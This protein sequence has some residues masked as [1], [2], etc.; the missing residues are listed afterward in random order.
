MTIKAVTS[1]TPNI[2]ILPSLANATT[3]ALGGN[4][5]AGLFKAFD[6]RKTDIRE[7]VQA[8]FFAKYLKELDGKT[9]SLSGFMQPLGEDLEVSSFMLIEYPVGCWYCEVPEITGIVL[10][11]LP[12]GK[13]TTFTR[14][15]VKITGKLTLN[16]T[17][18]EN[19]LF[20][21]SKVKVSEVD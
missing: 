2:A 3:F 11:E 5:F 1:L 4:W 16:R 9:I 15:L 18:P 13:T 19:F 20:T 7:K 21:I 6:V 8:K 17:D 14:T 10:G 12:P